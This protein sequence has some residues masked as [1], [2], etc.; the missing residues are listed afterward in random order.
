MS[1]QSKALKNY[2]EQCKRRQANLLDP[3]WGGSEAARGFPQFYPGM[4]TTEY[5]RRFQ[6]LSPTKEVNFVFAN[7]H[8]LN[9]APMLDPFEPEV[10]EELDL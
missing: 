9:A 3:A 2:K 10:L 5:V 7:K 1:A 8:S 4:T 6:G